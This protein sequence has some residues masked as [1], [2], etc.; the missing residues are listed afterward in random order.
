MKALLLENIHPAA[1]EYLEG[2]GYDV[3]L[4]AG[5]L[6]EDELIAALPG[7]SLLGIRSN[8]TVT[9]RV[10]DSAPDLLA[11]GCFCIGTNQV[12]LAA[13]AERGAL[14]TGDDVFWLDLPET[15]RALNGES[16]VELVE[17]RRFRTAMLALLR[18]AESTVRRLIAALGCRLV[19]TLPPP[20]PKRPG[21]RPS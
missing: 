14:R 17:Q 2:R 1:V 3:E 19:V 20:R 7:V 15:R 12:A 13:A 21:P 6:S 16:L 9:E 5:S 4:R 8:T 18:P 10:L 11:V